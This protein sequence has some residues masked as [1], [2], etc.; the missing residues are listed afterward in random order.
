MKD[1]DLNV[2]ELCALFRRTQPFII[3]LLKI[4]SASIELHFL[5]DVCLDAECKKTVEKS[6]KTVRAMIMVH[7][8]VRL[9]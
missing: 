9:S 5:F 8:S 2:V 4:A 6:L 1:N 3:Y 7:S